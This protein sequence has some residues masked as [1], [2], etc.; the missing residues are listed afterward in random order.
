MMRIWI[1]RPAD[2][3]TKPNN[4]WEPD[5][6]KVRGFVVRAKDSSEARRLAGDQAGDEGASPWLS[7]EYSTCAELKKSGVA[8]V[9][10]RD[11][12]NG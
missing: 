7:E 12:V 9:L 4:P 6:D 1:L 5:Y 3:L 11:F 2:G 8:G 10:V